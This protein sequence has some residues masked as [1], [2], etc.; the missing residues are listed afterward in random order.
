MESVIVVGGGCAGLRVARR[1]AENDI[2]VTVLEDHPQIGVPEHCSGLISARNTKELG[3]D[4]SDSRTN[5]IYGAKLYSPN[6]T[7]LRIESKEP[8]AHVMDRSKFDQ[9][10]YK[11]ALDA[12]ATVELNT[13]VMSVRGNSVFTQNKGRGGVRKASIIV[14]ADGVNSRLRKSAGIES[15]ATDFIHSYQ[16]KVAGSFD[17]R[18]VELYFG[19]DIAPHFFAWVIP[20]NEESA[21]VGLGCRMGMNPATVFKHFIREKQLSVHVKSEN[22][23]LIPC[24]R[25]IR[26][27][28]ADPLVLLG[29]AAFQTKATTGGGIIM[30]TKAADILGKV[31]QENI[32]HDTPLTEYEKRMAPIFRELE[33]HHRIHQYQASLTDTY[34]DKLFLKLK[35]AGMEEFL[36]REGDMDEPSRFISKLL[37]TPRMIT[38]LPEALGFALAK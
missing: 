10:L 3:F 33:L 23:F 2:P 7:Q 11:E 26:K 17:P 27:L 34:L 5:H 18:M 16:A 13:S 9:T 37:R 25:P 36:S 6:N 1:L 29:D 14:A 38:L 4:L 12:G 30:N 22:S 35:D 28:Y 31:I 15:K 8:V 19:T 32:A 21:K 20:E 24:A